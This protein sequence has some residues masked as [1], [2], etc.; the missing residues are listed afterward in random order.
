VLPDGPGH[1]GRQRH[2]P[3]FAALRKREAQFRSHHLDLPPNMDDFL[4]E[5]D[6]VR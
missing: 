2:V 5:V 3:D 1:A 4:L 6:V